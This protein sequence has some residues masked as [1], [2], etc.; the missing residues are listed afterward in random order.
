[1]MKPKNEYITKKQNS[2][3]KVQS[4]EMTKSKYKKYNWKIK[5]KYLKKN[6]QKEI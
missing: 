5:T 4:L 6:Y 3:S 2:K 1:M